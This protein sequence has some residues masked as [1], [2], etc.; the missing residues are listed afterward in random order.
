MK[1][2]NLSVKQTHKDDRYVVADEQRAGASLVAQMVKKKKFHLQ[3]RR[4]GFHPWVG[5]S[6]WRRAW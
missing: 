3:C 6:P 1:Q 5:K 4:P 2:M